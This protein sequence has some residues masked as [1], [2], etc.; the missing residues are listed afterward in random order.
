MCA[1]SRRGSSRRGESSENSCK[2]EEARPNIFHACY[3]TRKCAFS[4]A[5]AK[6]L[7]LDL[8]ISAAGELVG[9]NSG[10]VVRLGFL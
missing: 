3:M 1:L 7:P 2:E 10:F 5:L 8:P 6:L 4:V 9:H